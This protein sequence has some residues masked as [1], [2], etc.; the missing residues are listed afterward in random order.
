MR[1]IATLLVGL[2][3]SLPALAVEL[4]DKNVQQWFK[5]YEAV[6]DWAK[7]QDEKDMKFLESQRNPNG[8]QL[9]ALFTSSMGALKSHK[10]YGDFRGLL[11]SN[12][13][14]NPDEWAQL[15]DKVMAATIAVEMEKNLGTIEQSQAQM[16]QVMAQMKNNPNLSAEQKAQMEQM[17]GIGQQMMTTGSNV[18]AADKEV[19]KRNKDLIQRVL[20]KGNQN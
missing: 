10:F 16:A 14:S 1:F 4:T 7:K 18:P 11:K 8:P 15:G 2:A 6:L 20:E 9:D 17:M 13:F 19:I 12:G 3:L 5:S